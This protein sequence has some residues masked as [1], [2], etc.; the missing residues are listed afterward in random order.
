M[1]KTGSVFA[2]LVIPLMLTVGA[3][4]QDSLP[5]YKIV[6]PLKV[7]HKMGKNAFGSLTYNYGLNYLAGGIGTYAMVKWGTD[8]K[9]YR[10][11]VDSGWMS[12]A[13]YPGFHAQSALGMSVPVC[14]Y[15]AGPSGKWWDVHSKN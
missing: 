5:A 14:V 10:L 4:G 3:N 13:G 11:S 12:K 6:S 2:W 1:K 7:F 15:P 8:W 9:W